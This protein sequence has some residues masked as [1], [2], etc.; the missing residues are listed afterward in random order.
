MERSRTWQLRASEASVANS[1][2]RRFRTG[3]APGRPRQTGQTLVFGGAPKRLAQPQKA[4]VSVRSWTWTSSP[5]T[6]S[7]LARISGE[8]VTAV[9]IGKSSLAKTA[10]SGPAAAFYWGVFNL[11]M[12]SSGWI[13]LG[14]SSK[15]WPCGV[16]FAHQF[17]GRRLAR[18]EHHARL[19]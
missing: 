17:A 18:E 4:L 15:S 8:M 3:S 13:G 14:N 7:Y 19:R 9:A 11:A 16:G 1:T 2:A 5:M 12:S 10:L 6:G